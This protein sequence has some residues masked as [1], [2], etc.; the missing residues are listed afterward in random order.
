MPA[1][2]S[3]PTGQRWVG[4]LGPSNIVLRNNINPKPY[5]IFHRDGKH[6]RMVTFLAASLMQLRECGPINRLIMTVTGRSVQI[7]KK[8]GP[9]YPC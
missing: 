6:D 4:P 8:T 5:L 2:W 9:C 3:R 7:S 1:S